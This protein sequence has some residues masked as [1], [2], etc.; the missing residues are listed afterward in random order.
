[1]LRFILIVLFLL[2]PSCSSVQQRQNE[3][4]RTGVRAIQDSI[5]H[6]RYDLA[7]KYSDQ[8]SRIVPPPKKSV[9]IETFGIGTGVDRKDY[10]VLPESKIPASIIIE[11]SLEFQ[12]LVSD[13]EKLSKMLE[14]E[15]ESLETYKSSVDSSLRDVQDKLLQEKKKSWW[16]FLLAGSPFALGLALVGSCI[17]FPPL[18]PLVGNWF[19]SLI[20]S[21]SK[22]FG[23]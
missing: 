15:S 18:I 2:L 5:Q 11:N 17:A 8:V 7:K 19:S 1:M 10:T 3:S 12:K 4:L 13:N 22:L 9:S 14:H 23:R 21:I 6:N 16:A 20:S